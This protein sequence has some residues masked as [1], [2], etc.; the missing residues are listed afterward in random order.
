MKGKS[1]ADAQTIRG[2][3]QQQRREVGAQHFWFGEGGARLEL[4]FAVQPHA[5]P[6]PKRPQRPLRCSALA[7]EIGSMG[8]RCRRLRTL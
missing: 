1:S 8:R 6:G 4:L 7:R 2:Q 5:Q 3:A